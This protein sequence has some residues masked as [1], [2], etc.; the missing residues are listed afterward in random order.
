MMMFLLTVFAEK[1]FGCRTFVVSP[2]P[3]TWTSHSC[4]LARLSGTNPIFIYLPTK[5]GGQLYERD[6]DG[7]YG[8]ESKAH[9][10]EYLPSALFATKIL[11]RDKVEAEKSI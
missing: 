5:P 3:S 11:K 9:C 7:L 10:S 8:T 2:V 1:Y 4:K 6:S